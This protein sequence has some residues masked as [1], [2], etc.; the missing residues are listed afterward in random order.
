MLYDYKPQQTD[1]LKLKEGD[2]VT[3]IEAPAGGDWWK[4]KVDENEG[5]F[6][7]SYVEYI[8]MEAEEKKR[9]E[10]KRHS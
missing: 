2:V 4:G 6:P 9:K 1:D 5:W 8:D 10:G 3:L 7:K